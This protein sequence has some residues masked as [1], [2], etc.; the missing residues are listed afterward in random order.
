[1]CETNTLRCVVKRSIVC[2]FHIPNHTFAPVVVRKSS[3][4]TRKGTSRVSE[5]YERTVRRIPTKG[6]SKAFAMTHV[7]SVGDKL[8]ACPAKSPKNS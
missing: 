7:F 6:M 3:N 4:R 8:A 1:M 5:R 2:A